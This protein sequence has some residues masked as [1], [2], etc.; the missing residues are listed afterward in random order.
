MVNMTR[1]KPDSAT[2]TGE[3]ARVERSP[4]RDL[5]GKAS[6]CHRKKAG[7][8][9]QQPR[10]ETKGE[11]EQMPWLG[12]RGGWGQKGWKCVR[13]K[14]GD[15]SGPERS[16]RPPGPKSR[17]AGVRASVVAGKRVTT[18]ERRDAG[19]WMREGTDERKETGAS[20]GNASASRRSPRPLVVGGTERLDRTHV[21]AAH[22][23]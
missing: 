20:G 18:V 22:A 19:K 14:Q 7:S 16:S 2:P 8:T 17:P 13:G 3:P 5:R 21:D 1:R 15:P 23:R 6:L 10:A 4:A 12:W 11:R 9:G